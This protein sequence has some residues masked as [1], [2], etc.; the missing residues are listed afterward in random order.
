MA[1]SRGWIRDGLEGCLVGVLLGLLVWAN[2][3]VVFVGLTVLAA[4]AYA[5][6]GAL[7]YA[8]NRLRRGLPMPDRGAVFHILTW[9]RYARTA[10]E[11]WRTYRDGT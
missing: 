11:E 3:A 1:E 5:L 4:A 2:P 9:P 10:R 6:T 8:R 7:L